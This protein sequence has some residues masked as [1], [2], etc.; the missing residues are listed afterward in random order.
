MTRTHI[1]MD[2]VTLNQ[3]SLVFGRRE[4]VGHL[5]H[6]VIGHALQR[7]HLGVRERAKE[8]GNSESELHA[9]EVK[10]ETNCK[11]G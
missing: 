9:S 4:E 8:M 11:I 6:I 7:G 5:F 2:S 1:K 3:A 10:A